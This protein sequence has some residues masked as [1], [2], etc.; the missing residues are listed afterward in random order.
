MPNFIGGLPASGSPL[1]SADV[2]ENFLALDARTGKI[3]ARATNPASTSVTVDAGIVYFS[4][5]ISVNNAAQA[6]A[7]GDTTTGVSAFTNVGF[8]RDIAIVLRLSFN[9]ATGQYESTAT[10]VEGPEKSSST[11]QPEL[12]PLR[13]NDLPVARFVVRHN[14]I[15][16]TSKGQISPITQGQILDFRNY[17]DVGGVSYYSATVGDYDI[18]SDAY[19]ALVTDAYGDPIVSGETIGTFNRDGYDTNPIQEAIDSL[20]TTGGAV[21]IRRGIHT[22]NSTI[23]IPANVMLIGEGVSSVVQK[24]DDLIGPMFRVVGNDAKLE[25]LA[26]GGILSGLDPLIHL[27]GFNNCTI[28]DCYIENAITGVEIDASNRNV[29]TNNYFRGNSTAVSIVNGATKNLVATNQFEGNT[30]DIALSGSVD[31]T[32]IGNIPS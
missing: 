31:E 15:N 11:S 3:A 13:A 23:T 9:D 4:D 17:L 18:A 8:F 27:V 6:V 24:D 10:F 26:L 1:N 7:L 5:R 22:V 30:T 16:T 28:R 21:F 19:G 2:R 29:I 20:P 12:V 25:S 14:G 32:T